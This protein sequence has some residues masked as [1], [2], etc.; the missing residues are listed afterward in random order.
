LNPGTTCHGE[1]VEYDEFLRVPTGSTDADLLTYLDMLTH[2]VNISNAT[3][4]NVTASYGTTTEWLEQRRVYFGRATNSPPPAPPPTDANPAVERPFFF[5]EKGIRL[6]IPQLDHD[7]DL[8]EAYTDTTDDTDFKLRYITSTKLADRYTF[9]GKERG[10]PEKM[11]KAYFHRAACGDEEATL[12]KVH[13][14]ILF[15]PHT[16]VDSRTDFFMRVYGGTLDAAFKR[17]DVRSCFTETTE[18]IRLECDPAP[19]P[20]PPNDWARPPSPPAFVYEVITLA[21]ATGG[22]A[23]FFVISAVCCF[24]IAG[25]HVRD[26]HFSR[27]PGVLSQRAD[28]QPWSEE[29]FNIYGQNHHDGALRPDYT[30]PGEQLATGFTFMGLTSRY[31]PVRQ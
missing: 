16:Y 28:R 17:F 31:N 21:S 8:Q 29:H 3:L 25:K 2:Y 30:Q 11:P 15:Q 19:S 20:P 18:N 5:D 23:L 14:R 7:N 1:I 10:D 27:Y 9:A 24:G 13:V 4:I 22:S 6:D 26:R 12:V